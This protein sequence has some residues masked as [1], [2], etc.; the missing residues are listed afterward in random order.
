MLPHLVDVAIG[1]K[2][3]EEKSQAVTVPES[4]HQEE[5]RGKEATLMLK[6]RQIKKPLYPEITDEMAKKRGFDDLADLRD[7]VRERLEESNRHVTDALVERQIREKLLD[8]AKFDLPATLIEKHTESRVQKRRT[9]LE[10]RKVPE[11][12]ILKDLADFRKTSTDDLLRE[13]RLIFIMRQICKKEGIKLDEGD[14]DDR[15]EALAKETGEDPF[16]L[17][18][19]YEKSGRLDVLRDQLLQEKTFEL[20]QRHAVI[21]KLSKDEEEETAK[22]DREA[23]DKPAEA[24]AS[25]PAEAP[26]AAQA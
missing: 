24:A 25:G 16:D 7:E 6:I 9:E 26:P 17:R 14:L 13:M 19:A 21:R 20:I 23:A 22:A 8:L 4:F 18:E 10:A 2:A 5:H 15:I 3:G 12:E 1:G 11:S